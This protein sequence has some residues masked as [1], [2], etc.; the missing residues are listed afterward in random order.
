LL[1]RANEL[2]MLLPSD[3]LAIFATFPAVAALVK[4]S[5]LLAA[6]AVFAAF[7]AASAAA[8]TK[9]SPELAMAEAAPPREKHD[10]TTG[11]YCRKI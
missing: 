4:S 2:T 8:S 10:S 9:S 6:F 7:A 5:S 11:G 1:P 3:V